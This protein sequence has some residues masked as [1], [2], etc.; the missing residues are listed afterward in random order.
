MYRLRLKN[1]ST[2]TVNRLKAE[3]ARIRDRA[4]T[5]DGSNLVSILNDLF[6]ATD[7][8]LTHLDKPTF[9]PHYLIKDSD[10][11]PRLWNEN[12]NQIE[13]DLRTGFE[14]DTQL[15]LLQVEAQNAAIIATKA[16]E[17]R[18]NLAQSMIT[19]I[20]LLAGQLDQEVIVAG[21]DF[22]NMDKIDLGFPL[23]FPQAEVN[24]LQGIVTLK[25]LEAIDLASPEVKVTVTPI[26]PP[27]AANRNPTPDN[28]LRFYEGRFYASIGESRPEGGKWH[29]EERVRPGVTVP[30]S[31]SFTLQLDDDL[32]PEELFKGFPDLLTNAKEAAAARQPGFA[33]SPDDILVI[34]R[35]A[36]L[37]ELVA[38]RRRMVDGNPDTF[39]ECE[40]VL[41]APQLE[42]LSSAVSGGSGDTSPTTAESTDTTELQLAN[43][44]PEELRARAAR[45]DIDITDFEIEVVLELP[46]RQLVN[47]ITINPMNFSE[48]AWL[49]VTDVS[50]ARDETD[51]FL[52]V[53]GFGESLFDNILTNEANEELTDGEL[54]TTLAP[55]RYSY[56]GLGVFTFPPREALR[57]RIRLRQRTP[58]PTPYER[59][60][61]QLTRT[62][63]ATKTKVKTSCFPGYVLVDTP[64]GWRFISGIKVGDLV[65]SW[66]GSEKVA[67]HVTAVKHHRANPIWMVRL[68]D[69]HVVQTT[70]DHKLLTQYGWVK[71]K[72]LN[73]LYKLDRT[74]Q[75]SDVVDSFESSGASPMY[76]LYT[77]G[78]H[79]YI[80]DGNVVAHNFVNFR[81]LRTFWH[82]MFR[83]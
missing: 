31:T 4:R 32:P 59:T 29:L 11:D 9:K 83:D 37:E 48:T 14:E 38:I 67:R 46:S 79:N 12:M 19:D 82:R 47:F 44:T 1:P 18:A 40:F 62:L 60:A 20:R 2:L 35:G 30:G 53:E 68:E 49:E 66:N 17:E 71:A 70:S 26:S 42:A 23:T 78:E 27:E 41:H 69:G 13:T 39:W 36:Q 51:G 33:L 80:V 28:S 58:V 7:R 52:L 64:R 10:P 72:D 22:G 6:V 61:V 63:T 3:F 56:R 15:K 5:R 43:I 55:N 54:K 45:P 21:D 75:L 74:N 76:N 57:V 8:A 16:L 73:S 50:T 65:Y 81:K 25:R 24:T 34:D 77:A